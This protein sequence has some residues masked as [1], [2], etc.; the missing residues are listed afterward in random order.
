VK[1]QVLMT[2]PLRATKKQKKKI[3]EFIEVKKWHTKLMNKR[4]KRV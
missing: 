1:R 3:F 4:L 2:S